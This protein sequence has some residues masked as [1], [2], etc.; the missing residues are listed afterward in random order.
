[1]RRWAWALA[2]VATVLIGLFYL[3][4]CLKHGWFT[5]WLVPIP[6]MLTLLLISIPAIAPRR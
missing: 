5:V 1:L 4:N 3:Q 2:F 6:V